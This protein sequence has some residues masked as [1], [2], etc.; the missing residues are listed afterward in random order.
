M[1]LSR[2][3]RLVHARQRSQG[4][5]EYGAIAATTAFVCLLGL[6]VLTTAQKA[7][8]TDLPLAPV[9]PSAPGALLH[10]TV[11]A[12]PNCTPI[13]LMLGATLSC[14]A[15]MV[16]DNLQNV[17]D[18]KTP[19][20]T[21]TLYL[22][23]PS[24]LVLGSCT[25]PHS[26]GGDTNWCSGPVVSIPL[27]DVAL[28][29]DHT[30]VAQ[31]APESNHFINPPSAGTTITIVG[32]KFAKD[33]P[34]C[35]NILRATLNNMVEIGRPIACNVQV[36]DLATGG[37]PNPPIEV[38][39]IAPS[40][41]PAG[42]AGVPYLTCA[43]VVDDPVVWNQRLPSTLYL[44]PPGNRCDPAN[45]ST[46]GVRCTTDAVTGV[47]GVVFRRER[48]LM[49]SAVPDIG[50]QALFVSAAS[51]LVTATL[52]NA[53][54]V[55]A[56]YTTNHANTWMRC[57][58]Q[59]GR[60]EVNDS[61][62]VVDGDGPGPPPL[63]NTRLSVTATT[64]LTIYGTSATVSC[65]AYV[66]DNMPSTATAC[67]AGPACGTNPDRHDGFSPV[68]TI[69]WA[70]SADILSW[71][72]LSRFDGRFDPSSQAPN[73]TP[74]GSICDGSPANV[75]LTGKIGDSFDLT[76]VYTGPTHSNHTNVA[77]RVN[78]VAPPDGDDGPE[79]P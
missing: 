24:G 35:E 9:A 52:P 60:V 2:L 75:K 21:I 31:F 30:V 46:T 51:G 79:H 66:V 44:T 19:W 72:T 23:S 28:I 20:G 26:S 7:Y 50:F 43:I 48:N 54:H 38:T 17:S 59:Q 45:T 61:T 65:P 64:A 22:D 62:Y 63:N 18:R 56:S 73:G 41:G 29:G 76:A 77:V 40:L 5:V 14:D 67:S 6:N 42:G 4:L 49:G 68:G 12:A 10:P 69:S 8:F 1:L 15:P 74:Y 13:R 37:A 47:C 25:L 55:V 34:V 71:C 70:T 78:F 27:V 3:R 16:R 33:G 53:I 58:P 57:T 39:W 36:V 11:V 32:L